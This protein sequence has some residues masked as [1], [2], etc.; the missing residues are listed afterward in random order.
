M[1]LW[2][3]F[4]DDCLILLLVARLVLAGKLYKDVIPI[5]MTF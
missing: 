3:Q 1:R 2:Q 5:F 4:T